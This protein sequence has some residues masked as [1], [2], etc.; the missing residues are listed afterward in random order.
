MYCINCGVKL[1]DTEKHCPLCATPVY[2]PDL[3]QPAGEPQ[4][5]LYH[6][7]ELPVGPKTA[8]LIITALF[9]LPIIVTFPCDLLID[10]RLNWF[11]Y[12]SGALT[13]LYATFILPFWFKKPNPAIFVPITFL[14]VGLYLLYINLAT[15]GSWF[16]SFAFP[17]VTFLGILYTT[18]ATLL[19]YIRKGRLFIFGGAS[20]ALGLYIPLIEYF[21]V[22]TFSGLHF[23]GWSF[24]P[25]VVF[26]LL[27]GFLIFLGIHKPTREIM[28]R[29]F[30]L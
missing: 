10:G 17:L 25:L 24:L 20:L 13:V 6:Y 12:V 15:G 7:P 19:R 16:L 5:P 9:L 29:K 11:G 28:R 23:T 18:V 2:H 8:L 27:G 26:V 1:A 30:F 22:I 21:L 4:Y 3:K 14:C